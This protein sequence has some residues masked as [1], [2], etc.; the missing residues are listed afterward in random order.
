MGRSSKM[1]FGSGDGTTR[2]RC[3][4]SLEGPS[5]V[6]GQRRRLLVGVDR[7]DELG[8]I[9]EGGVV[10]VDLDHREE[11]GE[12]NLRREQVAELLLDQ[13]A[14]HPLG[15][16]AEHIQR[17]GLHLLVRGRLQREEA[18]LRAVAVGEH[19]L[20]AFRHRRQRLRRS[21]HVGSLHLGGH[22]LAA[23]EQRVA[24]ERHD[25]AH[26][27]QLPRV[28]TRRALIV[29]RRFSARSNTMLASDSKTAPVTSRP[30]V[31]RV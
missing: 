1:R 18:D 16:R 8:R 26:G 22:G 21:P 4:P 29:C 23:L 20:V 12:G 19:E 10:R 27:P 3:S 7:A 15:L 24:T 17:V 6:G 25:D 13:V 2:R 9:A 5:L 14:D 30:S 31:M 28:A 11:G